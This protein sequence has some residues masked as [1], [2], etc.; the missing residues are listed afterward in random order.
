MLESNQIGVNGTQSLAKANRRAF[1][2]KFFSFYLLGF[3]RIQTPESSSVSFQ[4]LP[5]EKNV[6]PS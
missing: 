6:P 4:V 3:S 5:P 2:K 1:S